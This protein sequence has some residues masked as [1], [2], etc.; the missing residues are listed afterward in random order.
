MRRRGERQ[1][2][3]DRGEVAA[4]P[5]QDAIGHQQVARTVGRIWRRTSAKEAGRV[6]VVQRPVGLDPIEAPV[7]GTPVV[8]QCP[9]EPDFRT[10][11]DKLDRGRSGVF[12]PNGL[13]NRRQRGIHADEV[14]ELVKDDQE[15]LVD[16]QV[17]EERRATRQLG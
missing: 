4:T 7:Q 5:T 17:A 11:K 1:R 2:R 10:T 16:G 15:T 3:I 13:E 9:K 8:V 14:A 12:V 6:V